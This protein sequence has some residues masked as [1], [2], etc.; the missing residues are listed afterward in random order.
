MAAN[1]VAQPHTLE[2][3]VLLGWMDRDNAIRFL[4]NSCIADPPYTPATAV[5]PHQIQDVIKVDL[6]RLVVHQLHVVIRQIE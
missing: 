2:G 3:T 6:S 4:V 5:G 1:S